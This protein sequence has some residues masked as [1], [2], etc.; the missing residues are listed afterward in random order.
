MQIGGKTVSQ[1]PLDQ[2]GTQAPFSQ[3]LPR[4][5]PKTQVPLEQHCAPEQAPQVSV[6]PQP[7]E[8]VPQFLP[9]AAQVVGK[10][11]EALKQTW[12]VPQTWLHAPQ[13]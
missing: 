6:P 3:Q 9:W 7:S 10:Q 12:P 8:I 5:Q 11:Q 13:S 1:Q 4:G 2:V